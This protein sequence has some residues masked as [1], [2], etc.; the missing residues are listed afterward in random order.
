[1][2][3]IERA[4]IMGEIEIAGEKAF[5]ILNNLLENYAYSEDNSPTTDILDLPKVFEKD[6][7]PSYRNTFDFVAGHKAIMLFINITYDYLY[8]ILNKAKSAT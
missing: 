2:T 8:D 3:D 4:N 6:S 5:E 1:M 7:P